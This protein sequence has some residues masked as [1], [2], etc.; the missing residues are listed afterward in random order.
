MRFPSLRPKPRLY[1]QLLELDERL[2]AAGWPGL[3]AF[4]KRTLQRFFGSK[5]RRL[6]L[7]VG[8]RGGKSLT[9]C[10]LALLIALCGEWTAALPPGELG[11]LA[12]LSVDKEEAAS[13]LRTITA[14]LDALGEPYARRG[15]EV[16]LE[17]RPALFRVLTATVAGVVGRTCISVFADEVSRWKDA[18]TGANPAREIIASVAPSM[19][20]IREARLFLVSS[21][22]S[23]TDFHAQEFERGDT[24]HQQVAQAATWEANPT[25]TEDQT[26][27]LEP[28]GPTWLREYAGRP[29]AGSTSI[30]SRAEYDACETK[31]VDR[32]EPVAGGFYAHL[33]DFGFRVDS[34]A[35]LTMHQ[36]LRAASDRIDE[37]VALDRLSVLAPTPLRKVTPV[38]AVRALAD[39]VREFGGGP[40]YCDQFH[41]D[42]MAALCLER[43]IKLVQLPDTPTALTTRIRSL[44]ARFAA[45]TVSLIEHETLRREVLAAQLQL[46]A[47]GRMTLRAPDRRGAHDDTVSVLLKA[48][49]PE[50]LGRLQYTAGDV[51][52]EVTPVHWDGHELSGGEIRYFQ[53]LPNGKR[54]PRAP[55]F[56]SPAFETWA[57]R[58]IASG[59]SHPDIERWKAE[60]ELRGRERP[61]INVPVGDFAPEATT[62]DAPWGRW[63]FGQSK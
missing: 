10:K 27:A 11:V 26:K 19:A 29:T 3:S 18:E 40:V 16:E 63:T 43:G 41:F 34:T 33:A 39:H 22:W 24:E 46:H 20:T 51:E 36:E 35:I 21:P 4:W 30:C 1:L 12:F 17:R 59:H 44:Q 60:R 9:M 50:V 31:G 42:S 8:R 54:V 2:R 47:G 15:D 32:R 57:E 23:E 45:G 14:M 49:D 5:A 7:R 25:L 56:G 28:H 55:P 53:R 37:V 61:P 6:V 52:T 38:D 13:R 62:R 48:C 58:M